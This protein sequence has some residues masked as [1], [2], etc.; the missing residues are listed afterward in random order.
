[1]KKIIM[2][3]VT[4]VLLVSCNRQ[5]VE[6]N[7][8]QTE[9]I[10]NIEVNEWTEKN[11]ADFDNQDKLTFNKIE[12]RFTELKKIDLEED[13]LM[14][15]NDDLESILNR[16]IEKLALEKNDYN[17]CNKSSNSNNCKRKL[18]LKNQKIDDC[19]I[20]V[21]TWSIIS[22]QNDINEDLAEKNL[23]ETFCN[24][25]IDDSEELFEVNNCKNNIFMEKAR[26]NQDI[27][28]CDKITEKIEKEMCIE[29]IKN[30]I[31]S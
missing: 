23:D 2:L 7:D 29:N 3:F 1:M 30:E 8:K 31:E 19:K 20:L 10:I 25:I 13:E 11:N 24:K 18:I 27:K 5:N 12:E 6:Q 28:I 16:N 17:L 9:K 26:K 22:C 21:D 4:T 14:F 15:L